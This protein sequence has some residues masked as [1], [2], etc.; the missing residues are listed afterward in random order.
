VLGDEHG[1]PAEGSL[2]AVVAR[3]GRREPLR[4]QFTRV[5]EDCRK[6]LFVEIP[7]LARAE[8]ESLAEGRTSERV[9][10]IIDVS[11]VTNIETCPCRLAR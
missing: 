3:L 11:H 2:P 8:P 9:E 1:M 5:V 4:D 6:A 10:E 7:T